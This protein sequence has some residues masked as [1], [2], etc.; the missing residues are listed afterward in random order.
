[1]RVISRRAIREFAKRHREALE[2]L[3]HWANATESA[4]WRSPG[5][6]RGTFN[7]A[8]FVGDLT[9][10]NV[11][12]NRYRVIAFVHYRQRAV[13]IKGVLTHKEYDKGAWKR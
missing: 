4:D 12:G 1:V 11:G 10:F 6:V 13:Y 3:L 7:T 2:P 9:V 5:D 8:D